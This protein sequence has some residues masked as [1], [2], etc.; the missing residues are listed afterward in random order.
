MN[1]QQMKQANRLQTRNAAAR[2]RE[3]ENS[4][5]RGRP[6]LP[7][8]SYKVVQPPPSCFFFSFLSLEDD[9]PRSFA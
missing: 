1:P 9:S 6:H 3:R 5:E 4:R 8:M 7:A 2:E